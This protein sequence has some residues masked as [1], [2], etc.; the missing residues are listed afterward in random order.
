MLP[1]SFIVLRF[2][3]CALLVLLCSVLAFFVLLMFFF[4]FCKIRK[5]CLSFGLFVCLIVCLFV[6]LFVRS[7][8]CLTSIQTVL[9]KPS[10]QCS[11]KARAVLK[12]LS[13]RAHSWANSLQK[14]S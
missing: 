7:F 11:G 6:R 4:L 14:L 2:A 13:R 1:F 10:T 8:V 9:K 5:Y 3:L 12:Q